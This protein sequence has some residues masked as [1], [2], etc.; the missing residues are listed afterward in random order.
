[1][2]PSLGPKVTLSFF[3]PGALWRFHRC[4]PGAWIPQTRE[5][6]CPPA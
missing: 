4:N 2:V 3:S 1:M 6:L 5:G